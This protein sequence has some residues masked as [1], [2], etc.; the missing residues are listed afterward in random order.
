MSKD[1]AKKDYDGDGKVE[2]PRDEYKGSKSKAIGAAM[3]TKK[4]AAKSATKKSVVKESQ[5]IKGFITSISTKKY[6]QA[7][8]YLKQIVEDKIQ[9]K[10]TSSLHK[11]LF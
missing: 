8:K 10:I 6:A 5:A 3:A 11:P 2:S 7:H 1:K 4:K 9:T